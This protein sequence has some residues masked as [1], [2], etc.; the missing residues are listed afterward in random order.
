MVVIPYE[1]YTQTGSSL[2]EGNGAF[3]VS[4]HDKLLHFQKLSLKVSIYS[5]PPP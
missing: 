1:A 2:S 4:I 3:L 5:L